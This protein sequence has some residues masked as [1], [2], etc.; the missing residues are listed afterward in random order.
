MEQPTKPDKAPGGL[1]SPT[2][3]EEPVNGTDEF[4]TERD[5]P[6]L[7]SPTSGEEPV[8]SSQ[9]ILVST[10]RLRMVYVLQ[11][12]T[13]GEEPVNLL[14]KERH[15]HAAY[16][17]SPTS[18]DES[19]NPDLPCGLALS[20][21]ACS[22]LPAGRSRSTFRVWLAGDQQ[23]HLQSPTGGAEPFNAYRYQRSLCAEPLAVP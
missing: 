8:N 23:S 16:L 11:S 10:D 9:T 17:Q 15:K 13:R 6:V 1:Q 12:P 18:G 3:G 4:I 7:R 2:S 14:W 19:F 20:G 21:K 22:S 5:Y